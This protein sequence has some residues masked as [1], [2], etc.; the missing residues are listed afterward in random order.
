MKPR[1]KKGQQQRF[2]K[3]NLVKISHTNASI[4]AEIVSLW[5][6]HPQIVFKSD[7]AE[8]QDPTKITSK[9]RAS[10]LLFVIETYKIPYPQ[11]RQYCQVICFRTNELGWISSEF[12]EK[13]Q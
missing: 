12:L 13:V 7:T 11:N 4:T 1:L 10:D 9:V 5:N 3:G 8:W 6:T 2:R